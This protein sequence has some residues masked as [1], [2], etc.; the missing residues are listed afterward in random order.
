MIIFDL[1]RL[2]DPSKNLK[3]DSKT[4]KNPK[5][6]LFPLSEPLDRPR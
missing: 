2:F 1:F 3:N 5:N 6:D 4:S